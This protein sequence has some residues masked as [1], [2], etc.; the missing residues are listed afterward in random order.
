MASVRA[1]GKLEATTAAVLG[2]DAADS[3]FYRAEKLRAHVEG[4][5]GLDA[6]VRGYAE[7]ADALDIR[8]GRF[9]ARRLAVAASKLQPHAERTLALVQRLVAFDQM[10]EGL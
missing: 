6:F 2:L 5:L 1:L 9:D 8:T 4:T 10:G 3:S 7:V